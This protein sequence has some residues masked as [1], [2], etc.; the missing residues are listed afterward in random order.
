MDIRAFDLDEDYLDV[1]AWWTAQKWP[2]LPKDHLS[3]TGFITYDDD[4]KY[5]AAW[6]YTTNSSIYILDWWVG[7]PDADHEKRKEGMELIADASAE[8]AKE[9]GAKT[10]LTMTSNARFGS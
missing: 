9:C 7:N 1:C 2:I 4:T 8:F 10:L 5:A 3:S 6:V